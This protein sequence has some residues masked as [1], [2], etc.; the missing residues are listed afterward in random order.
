LDRV[1]A[2]IEKISNLVTPP[3]VDEVVASSDNKTKLVSNLAARI[4]AFRSVLDAAPADNK[5]KFSARIAQLYTQML[6]VDSTE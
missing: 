3:A 2:H 6:D 1:L 5:E 4:Q